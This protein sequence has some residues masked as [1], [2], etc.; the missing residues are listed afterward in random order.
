MGFTQ[1]Q[2]NVFRHN[3]ITNHLKLIP[4]A[5]AIQPILKQI[6]SNRRAQ[7]V[8]PSKT[9]KSYKMKVPYIL[10]PLETKNHPAILLGRYDVQPAL[11]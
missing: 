9:A 2:M 7:K 11:R 1:Q 10:I 5:N 6:P 4:A 3:N 8:T